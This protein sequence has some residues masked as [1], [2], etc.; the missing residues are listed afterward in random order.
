MHG[1]PSPVQAVCRALLLFSH[2][3][4]ALSASLFGS[5]AY[6]RNQWMDP[7]IDESRL[8]AFGTRCCCCF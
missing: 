6:E 3:P 8:D 5:D 2:L 7:R 1:T 4:L